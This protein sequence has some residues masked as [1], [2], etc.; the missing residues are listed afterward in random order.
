[1][2]PVRH[3]N[4]IDSNRVSPLKPRVLGFVGEAISAGKVTHQQ[5]N[6]FFDTLVTL[7]TYIPQQVPAGRETWFSFLV[8]GPEPRLPSKLSLERR[9]IARK[10]KIPKPSP[11]LPIPKI[12]HPVVIHQR[13]DQ[14]IHHPHMVRMNRV[15]SQRSFIRKMHHHRHVKARIHHWPG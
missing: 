14:L 15:I 4:G 10:S 5:Q 1:M 3:R 6:A 9:R 11:P 12:I 8:K 2:Q 13:L 7:Q